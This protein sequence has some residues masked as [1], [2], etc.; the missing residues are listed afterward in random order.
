MS[1]QIFSLRT[2]HY[3]LSGLIDLLSTYLLALHHVQVIL[4]Q[5]YVHKPHYQF[6]LSVVIVIENVGLGLDRFHVKF[7]KFSSC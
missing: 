6:D 3:H 5:F 7:V 1:F 2:L 4:E